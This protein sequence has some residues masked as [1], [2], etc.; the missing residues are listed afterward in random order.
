MRFVECLQGT[1]EW[2]AARTGKITASC[3]SAAVSTVGGLDDRQDAYV[4][5]VRSGIDEKLAASTAGYKAVPTSDLVRRAIAG[6]DTRQVSDV[7]RRYAADLMMEQISGKPYGQPARSWILDRGHEMEFAA[8]MRYEARTGSFVTEAGLCL[9]D[10]EVF[11]YSTDGLVDQDGLIEIKAPVDSLKVMAMWETGDVSEYV[12]QM[13]GG[14]WITGRKWCD[15]IM[16]V[17]DLANVGKD[18][19][20]K[21]I[22]RDD[23]FIDAMVADLNRFAKMVDTYKALI[24]AVKGPMQDAHADAPATFPAADW[25]AQIA[26]L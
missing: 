18:L 25:R 16:Y 22:H 3:F 13:Q 7:A 5:A 24:R 11:G 20:I 21:R 17:P 2:D 4:K 19:F 15:F 12:H 1:P 8:R 23:A 14:M 6:E 10:D 26:R 9:T